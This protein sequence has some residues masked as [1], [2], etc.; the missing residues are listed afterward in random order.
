[1]M[2][3][4]MQEKVTRPRVFQT[5]REQDPA[6]LPAAL[7][8][9][10][11][12]FYYNDG[13]FKALTNVNLAMPRHRVTALIGPSGCGK[14]TFL[15]AIN[16][17]HD[18]TPGARPEGQL[19]LDGEDI[20]TMSDLT[21]LRKRVGMIFQR[22]NPF[23]MSIFDNVAYGLRLEAQPTL[24]SEIPGRVEQALRDAYLWDEV[25]GKLRSSGMA[26]S[27]GQQQRLCIARALAVQPEV[28]LMDEPCAA[29]DP[30]AT[31]AI[32]DLIAELTQ[33]YTIVIVTHNMGQAA[34]VSH[35]T[36]FFNADASRTGQLV[37]FGPTQTI[38]TNPHDHR[39]EDYISGRFG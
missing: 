16:R 28:L 2:S 5:D 24:K 36:A 27:G 21:T 1:M 15:R 18:R 25:K 39:T 14:T 7:E 23:P 9:R 4:L 33:R 29:L 3:V 12:G 10:D 17:M 35:Y 6:M 26:L 19:L 13:A 37:E 20:N 22:A 34:R 11:F 32:E 8:A 30:I 38:F 31:L